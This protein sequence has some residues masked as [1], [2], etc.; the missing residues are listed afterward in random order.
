MA[1]VLFS[2]LFLEQLGENMIGSIVAILT[3]ALLPQVIKVTKPRILTYSTW[4]V[5]D[6]GS[7]IALWLAHGSAYL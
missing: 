7:R 1:N 4:Y 6:A 2:G 5:S 3:F